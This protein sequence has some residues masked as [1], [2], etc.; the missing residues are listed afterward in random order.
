MG[1]AQEEDWPDYIGST[2]KSGVGGYASGNATLTKKSTIYVNVGRKNENG[3]NGK[4]GGGS[5]HISLKSGTL[6][7]LE[8]YKESMLLVSKGGGSSDYIGNSLLTNKAMYCYNC[9]DSSEESTKTISTT[10]AE[11]TPTENCAKKGNGYARITK[12][13]RPKQSISFIILTYY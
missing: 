4:R 2:I 1:G 12:T 6:L 7:S 3:S 9:E 11:E 8:S 13:D 10:R 5:T